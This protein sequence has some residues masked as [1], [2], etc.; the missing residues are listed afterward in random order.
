[1]VPLALKQSQDG[2]FLTVVSAIFRT[3][4]DWD[5]S[6]LF[7]SLGSS[8]RQHRRKLQCSAHTDAFIPTG[9]ANVF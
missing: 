6:L 3:Q 2:H 1:M 5:T 8:E 7:E 4:Q 9:I